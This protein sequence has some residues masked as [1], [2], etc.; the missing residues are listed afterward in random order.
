MTLYSLFGDSWSETSLKLLLFPCYVIHGLIHALVLGLT[1]CVILLGLLYRWGYVHRLFIFLTERELSSVLNHTPVSIGDVDLSQIWK[2]RIVGRDVILHS[3]SRQIWKWDSPCIVRLGT[4]DITVSLLTVIDILRPYLMTPPYLIDI[5]SIHLQDIQCFI[6]RRQPNIFNFHLLD[7]SL[8]IPLPSATNIAIS[9]DK[10]PVNNDTPITEP[11]LITETEDEQSA[12]MILSKL[13]SLTNNNEESKGGG[14]QQ[15]FLSQL[16]QWQSQLDDTHCS[17]TKNGTILD[18]LLQKSQN[19]TNGLKVVKN[20]LKQHVDT[21]LSSNKPPPKK[22]GFVAPQLDNF[23]I[24]RVMLEHVHIFT[25]D[26]L[27]QSSNSIRKQ[28]FETSTVTKNGTYKSTEDTIN[29]VKDTTNHSEE[30]TSVD[31]SG[32]QTPLYIEKYCISS[33]ELS[34]PAFAREDTTGNP[35][36]GLS[37]DSTINILL[38]HL[39]GELAERNAGHVLGNAYSEIHTWMQSTIQNTSDKNTKNSTSDVNSNP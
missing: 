6:E 33:A 18:V 7:D 2:G 30:Q 25:R 16:K 31:T 22:E 11:T 21:I 39:L 36:L 3:P 26:I 13:A 24:G 5:Y 15:A 37:I 38:K 27:L 17:E 14:L 34:P 29:N 12:N 9:Q 8:D 23:R 28:S 1:I 35:V 32:W 19:Q 4:V 20:V 10:T